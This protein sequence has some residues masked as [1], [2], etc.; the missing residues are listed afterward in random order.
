MSKSPEPPLHAPAAVI[1]LFTCSVC[2]RVLHD[3]MMNSMCG[4]IH[5]KGCLRKAI[6]GK[7]GGNSNKGTKSLKNLCPICHGP[8]FLFETRKNFVV[9]TLLKILNESSASDD[10]SDIPQ[11]V[12]PQQQLYK[13]VR[14]YNTSNTTNNPSPPTPVTD[15]IAST[16]TAARQI[17]STT[18]PSPQRSP[19]C[20]QRVTPPT[21]AR[22]TT[23]EIN[24]TNNNG[25]KRQREDVEE[26]DES[27]SSPLIHA[28]QTTS[29]HPVIVASAMREASTGTLYRTCNQL[30]GCVCPRVPQHH[31]LPPLATHLICGN[32]DNSSVLMENVTLR[33]CEGILRGLWLVDMR[34]A[35]ASAAAGRWVEEEPYEVSVAVLGG[36]RRG[37]ERIR[38][39]EP[40]LFA[41]E[42]FY[43]HGPFKDPN[44]QAQLVSCLRAGGGDILETSPVA[45]HHGG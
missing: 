5:C 40:P 44:T 4:H 13:T 14:V 23:E 32:C 39:G 41:R 6:E 26:A 34:W 8:A 36:P 16:T 1:S 2:S 42:K 22:R 33:M 17:S 11:Q 15:V 21:E 25:G 27:C 20:D 28:V 30:G 38:R 7:A 43:L 37:R 9:D 3:P 24:N 31:P 18:T 12:A 35:V 10:V 19:K 29:S 45:T